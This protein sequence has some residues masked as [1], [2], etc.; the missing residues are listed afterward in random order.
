[1]AEQIKGKLDPE[2]LKKIGKGALIAASGG[3][4]LYLLSSLG[5]IDVGNPLLNSFLATLIPAGVNFIKEWMKGQEV[6]I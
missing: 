2:T 5:M 4:G 1:M 3:A 6:E